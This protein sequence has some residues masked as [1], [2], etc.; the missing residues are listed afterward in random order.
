LH[1]RTLKDRLNDMEEKHQKSRSEA[2]T[3][4][5][6][7]EQDERDQTKDASSFAS[8]PVAGSG[9]LDRLVDTAKDYARHATAENTNAAYKAD[10]AHFGSWCR[11]RG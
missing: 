1:Y 2:N 5:S 3:A 10:W 11:R 7:A 4:L 9:G 6:P 8:L